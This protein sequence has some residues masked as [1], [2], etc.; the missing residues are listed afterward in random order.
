MKHNKVE[1]YCLSRDIGFKMGWNKNSDWWI[2]IKN[3]YGKTFYIYK[4]GS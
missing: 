4:D 2:E 1:E 3:K